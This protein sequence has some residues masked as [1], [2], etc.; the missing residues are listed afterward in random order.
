MPIPS[1]ILAVR[2]VLA[3][4]ILAQG[5]VLGWEVLRVWGFVPAAP[6][7]AENIESSMLA[8]LASVALVA[9]L[10]WRLPTAMPLRPVRALAALRSYGTWVVPWIGLLVGYLWLVPVQAQP[11]LDYL[12]AA[13]FA[14]PGFWAVVVAITVGAPLAEEIV[15]RGYLQ[16]ALQRPL[17]NGGAI[18][19]SAVVFGLAHGAS[20]AF[21]IGVLGLL[22]GWLAVHRGLGAAML[23][24]ALHNG[25]TVAVTVLWPESLDLIYR[26]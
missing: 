2:F 26:R 24:H 1:S 5:P 15:F 4:V 17:G 13:E 19:A 20:Y 16:G 12:A 10:A 6:T 14:R 7:F 23:A 25:L 18:A 22:F 11:P 3:L 9:L 21:P 8:F